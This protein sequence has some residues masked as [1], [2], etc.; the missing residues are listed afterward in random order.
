MSKKY[1]SADPVAASIPFDNST[2][3]FA[4][5]M[6]QQAIEEAKAASEGFPRSGIRATS[7]GFLTNN[8]WIGPNE[9]LSNTPLIIAPVSLKINE[10]TWANSN[11]NVEFT[12]QFRLNSKTGPIVFSVTG[13]S[14]NSGSGFVTG[15][16]YV[17]NPGQT[18]WAQYIDNGNNMNDLDLILWVSRSS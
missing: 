11:T 9:L 18:L 17:L 3:G 8:E 15:V 5:D 2:N 1:Y 7:N 14:P 12:I 4:S 16:N 13:T 6:T 10:I